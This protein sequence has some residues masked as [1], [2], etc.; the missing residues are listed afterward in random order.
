MNSNVSGLITKLEKKMKSY[1]KVMP[2]TVIRKCYIYETT[3]LPEDGWLQG[4][5]LCR[6]ITSKTGIFMVIDEP[7]RCRT[8]KI[9]AYLCPLCDKS[10]CRKATRAKFSRA[11]RRIIRETFSLRLK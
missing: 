11:C 3:H 5:V 6:E 7:K 10:L 8:S 9:Y 1:N 2:S 4:C